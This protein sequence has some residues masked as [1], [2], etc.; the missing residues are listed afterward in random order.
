M[1][2]SC[3]QPNG[4]IEIFTVTISASPG[5]TVTASPMSGPSGTQIIVSASPNEG[6]GLRENSLTFTAAGGS[7]VAITGTSFILP[8]A[9]VTVNAVFEPLPEGQFSVTIGTLANGT[10][11]ASP[12]SGTEGTEITLTISPAAGYRLRENT[13]TFTAAGGSPVPITGTSFTLP[14]ANVTVNAEFEPIPGEQF[15]V[16]IGTLVNGTISANPLYG[17]VGTVINLAINPALGYRLR[18][19]SLTFTATATGGSPVA[20]TGTSFALP[21][22]NVTVNAEFEQLPAGHFSVTIGTL[23]NGTISANPLYGPVGTVINLSIKPASGFMLRENTL[24]FTAEGSNPVPIT[25]TSFVLPAANVTVNAVFEQGNVNTLITRGIDA[26]LDGDFDAAIRAFEDAYVLDSNNQEAL[27]YSSLARLASIAVDDN[28]RALVRD[29]LGIRNYPGTINAL[30]NL[31]WMETYT[32]ERFQ[33]EIWSAEHN[34][35]AHWFYEN[36][37]FLEWAGLPPRSGYYVMHG[38]NWIMTLIS[39]DWDYEIGYYGMYGDHWVEWIDESQY[40]FF[41]EHQ[42]PPRSGYYAQVEV[43][44]VTFVS[45]VRRYDTRTSLLPGLDVPSW[46]ENTGVFQNTLTSASLKSPATFALLMFTNL[47]DRNTDG[48]NDL[49]D[50]LLS[51][52]FGASFDEAARRAGALTDTVMLDESLLE[53]LGINDIFEGER[54]AIG[55]AELNL[56]FSLMRIVR[57][58]LEWIAAYDWN[59]DLNFLA[60]GQLWDDW[61]RIENIELGPESLPLRNNFLRDRNN[62]M[63]AR[64]KASFTQALDDLIWSYDFWIGNASNLPPAYRDILREFQWVRSGV[65]EL[66]AAIN[67]GGRFYVREVS[68][69]DTYANIPAGAFFGIDLGAFFTPGHFA[70]DKLLSTQGSGNNMAPRFYGWHS[71]GNGG[72]APMPDRM[73]NSGKQPTPISSF[74][75]IRNF[76]VIGFRLNL[77]PVQDLVVLGL[78]FDETYVGLQLMPPTIAE[79]IWGWYHD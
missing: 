22:A 6:Y 42:L 52:V 70:I 47:I 77:Q 69:S 33:W 31:D 75:E 35:W 64:S 56:L 15:S 44:E 41:E 74:A 50:A 71:N 54:V 59:T 49:L 55:R 10:I 62:G 43:F 78:E 65:S 11:S 53:A 61:A 63:M 23:V 29:R 79:M 7:P 28:V 1:F 17:P 26:L 51:S 9:N 5:G 27:L 2:T 72:D 25:G 21:A 20:I 14:A 16:T 37:W 67:T 12:L 30:V 34:R 32:D 36:D 24:T 46:I 19:N 58:S 4:E 73:R 57:G 13:L 3:P 60:D 38:W 76:D 39:E 8:A 68:D 66:R 40:W 45:D 18:E 48:L